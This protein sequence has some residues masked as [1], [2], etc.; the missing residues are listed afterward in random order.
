MCIPSTSCYFREYEHALIARMPRSYDICNAQRDPF[1]DVLERR[2][3]VV[4][5]VSIKVCHNIGCADAAPLHDRIQ[6]QLPLGIT[7]ICGV[8]C[9]THHERPR[10]VHDATGDAV[11]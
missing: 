3:V 5:W 11:E 4:I 6:V 8:E 1:P 10:Y 7:E 2:E 9:P